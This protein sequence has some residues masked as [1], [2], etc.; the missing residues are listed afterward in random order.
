MGAGKRIY[1][2]I[3]FTSQKKLAKRVESIH[4]GG[5]YA[6]SS[7]LETA[8]GQS[9]PW[10]SVARAERSVSAT[11]GHGPS[12]REIRVCACASLTDPDLDRVVPLGHSL[13]SPDARI[14]NRGDNT[15]TFSKAPKQEVGSAIPKFDFLLTM[16]VSCDVTKIKCGHASNRCAF[17]PAY[18][19]IL[20]L[21]L[22]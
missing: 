6:A 3:P 16:R 8:G 4:A 21:N 22:T 2:C 17:L 12:P 1:V 20:P 13:N 19:R 14:V 9:R 11:L 18:W 15:M 10:N 5:E 7:A